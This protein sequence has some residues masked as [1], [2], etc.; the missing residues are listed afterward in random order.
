MRI[1]SVLMLLTGSAIASAN[2]VVISHRV[3]IASEKLN[4][5][6]SQREAKVSGSFLLA[7]VA[8]QDQLEHRSNVRVQVSIWFPSSES[9][10]DEKTKLFWR[11]FRPD[12]LNYLNEKNRPVL[13]E[14]IGLRVSIGKEPV[15][16]ETFSVFT[17]DGPSS[18]RLSKESHHDGFCCLVFHFEFGPALLKR[19]QSLSISYQQPLLSEGV[20]GRFVYVPFFH[21]LP[22]GATT[23]DIKKYSLTLK[24]SPGTV[25]TISDSKQTK[26]L[27]DQSTELPLAHQVPIRAV[28]A[29]LE[30]DPS[31]K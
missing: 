28:A 26:V 3:Y 20:A 24:A 4:V 14:V 9:A 8:N 29:P 16:C 18:D 1:L 19:S 22:K 30:R 23:V 10:V 21:N 5:T 31:A 7:S 27:P 12:V 15:K 2:P 17:T 13:D 6:I 11:T 25:V